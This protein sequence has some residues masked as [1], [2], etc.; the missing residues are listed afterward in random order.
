MDATALE[1]EARTAIA[2]AADP[3]ALEELR[4]RYLGRKSPL[5]L[6]LR[7]VRDRETGMALNAAREPRSRQALEQREREL[8]LGRRRGCRL[9]RHAPRRRAA[10][11]PAAPDHAGPA[12]RRGRVPR[13]RL[14]GAGRPRGRDGRVQ[15]RQAR[16]PGVASRAL[17]ARHVLLRRRRG[18]CAPRRRRRRS[19]SWK[20]ASRRSTWSR[21]AAC[22]GATR[23]TRRTSRS[24]TS[25]KGSPSTAA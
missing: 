3:D 2:A 5:K 15:L 9:R 18:S 12:D 6:A 20:S 22:T 19:T 14:R 10:A 25:S 4:V 16:V 1:S 8:E 21:S 24:S 23:S 7:E 13:A 11:R 17:A